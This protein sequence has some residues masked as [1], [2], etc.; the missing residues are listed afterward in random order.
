MSTDGVFRNCLINAM[1]LLKCGWDQ[2]NAGIQY[3]KINSTWEFLWCIYASGV[4]WTVSI[5][6]R[7]HVYWC[8]Q[9]I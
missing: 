4:V 2:S 7:F 1:L 9:A 6:E 8:Y 3:C 5:I